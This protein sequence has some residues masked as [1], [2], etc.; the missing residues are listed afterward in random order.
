MPPL[1]RL[2]VVLA[3]LVVLV[4][5]QGCGSDDS[6]GS[7]DSALGYLPA[8]TPF[9]IA[10]D[11]DLEGEQFDSLD[12]IV[13]KFPFGETIRDLVVQGLAQGVTGV[14][15]EK[16]VKPL[17]GNPFVVGVTDADSFVGGDGGAGFV[18]AIEVAD[19]GKLDD[20][21]EKLGATKE[22]EAAGA[23]L[24]EESGTTFAVEDG[25]VVFAETREELE[26]ALERNDGDDKLDEE[27]FDEG[28]EGLSD[29]GIARVYANLGALLAG[30]DGLEE[31]RRVKWIAALQGLGLDLSLED[32]R[33][34]IDFSIKTDSEGLEDADLPIASGDEA[35][36]IVER[37]G[38]IA[39]GVR[40][41]GQIVTFVETV[42]QAVDPSGFGDYAAAKRTLEERLDVD[43]ERDLLD[44]LSGDTT[45]SISLDGRFGVRAELKDPAA[46]ERTLAKVADVLPELLEG[47]GFDDVGL[48]K[49]R[50][51]EDFYALAEPDGTTFVFGV[52]NEVFVLAVDEERAS[53]MATATPKA[54]PGAKGAVVVSA[55]AEEV[56]NQLLADIGSD[57]GIPDE[58]DPKI[59]TKPLGQLTGWLSADTESVDGKLTLAL[60]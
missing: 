33:I 9:A 19:E 27:K 50:G 55:D 49:P 34:T 57:L 1:A 11:T 24:Y 12:A 15:L 51:G 36:K 3:A 31:V 29:D 60:D 28:R 54:V 43:V 48:S 7:L 44:Q 58:I 59:F 8:D 6:G 20:L 26:A 46:F 21:L 56:A 10:I 18:A 17:L 14:S 25:V 5:L 39:I 16:D 45:A 52:V 22:G 30:I 47:A 2:A 35:P 40:D 42:A 23:T 38:E 53:A 13:K 41:L 4:G 37:P 32:D